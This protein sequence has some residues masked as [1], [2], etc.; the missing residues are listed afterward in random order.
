MPSST[1][2]SRYEVVPT[3]FGC[4]YILDAATPVDVFADETLARE[5]AAARA[6]A[7]KL[8]ARR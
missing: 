8:F 1:T 2:T 6:L 7:D 5:D 4:F 3:D